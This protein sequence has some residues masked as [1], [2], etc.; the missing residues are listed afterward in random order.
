MWIPLVNKF[1][2]DH[3]GYFLPHEGASNIA[4]ALFSF[5]S[6]AKYEEYREKIKTDENCMKAFKYAKETKCI[7]SLERS[8]MK[9]IF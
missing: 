2:G 5:S 3:H 6:L 8:F 7:Y 4:Y 1:G 9:P